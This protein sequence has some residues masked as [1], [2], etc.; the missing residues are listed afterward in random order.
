MRCAPIIHFILT[1]F[2]PDPQQPQSRRLRDGPTAVMKTL[3][4]CSMVG[5]APVSTAALPSSAADFVPSPHPP[6]F[7]FLHFDNIRED[8]CSAALTPRRPPSWPHAL[9]CPAREVHRGPTGVADQDPWRSHHRSCFCRFGA[10]YSCLLFWTPQKATHRFFVL[11]FCKLFTVCNI[12]IHVI[13]CVITSNRTFVSKLQST[14][15]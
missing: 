14:Y 6:F 13:H 15:Q 4:R 2:F 10:C 11:C 12:F 5:G 1:P 3:I 8:H 9:H 7:F